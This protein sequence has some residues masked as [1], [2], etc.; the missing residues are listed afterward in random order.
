MSDDPNNLEPDAENT[1]SIESKETKKI[2]RSR[3]WL[4][5]FA[6]MALILVVGLAVILFRGRAGDNDDTTVY[7]KS[8]PAQTDD[9]NRG[10]QTVKLLP[11]SL[12]AANIETETVTMQ[13]AVAR[14]EVTG[15]VEENPQK[16][17]SVSSLVGGRVGSVNVSIGDRVS[18]GQTLATLTSTDAADMFGKWRAA[19]TK[20]T[21]AQNNLARVRKAENRVGVLQA[22]AKLDEAE[23]TLRR[24]QRLIELGAGA[25]K[26]LI[27]A[28]AAYKTALAD[29]NYQQTIQ[30]NKEIQEAEA[31]VETARSES[32]NLRQSLQVL[33]I[34]TS[35]AGANLRKVANIPIPAPIGG[36]ITER[37]VNT[38]A[39]VQ[40]GQAM[41]SIANISSLWITANVPQQELSAIRI[42]TPAEIVSGSDHI[43]S[44]VS[45]IDPQ[46]N[47]ETRTAKV[48]MSVTNPG[49]RLRAGMF[50]NVA[51]ETAEKVDG[52]DVLVAPTGSIQHLGDRTFVFIP[53]DDEPGEFIIRDVQIGA[54][55]N[56]YTEIKSG[57]KFGDK[58][59]VKG[60][61]AL[62][63]QMQKGSIEDDD[64]D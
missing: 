24:T 53:K 41:F 57:L 59:V 62:K 52:A 23:A 5:T 6:V 18:A 1:D 19:Q 2:Y 51:F 12:E 25:G 43:N 17:E 15:T 33:G 30:L 31:D 14:L 10:E 35:D 54:E 42:G 46:L 20:L 56:G 21:L 22:K 40:A 32:E 26:D 50:V 36:V 16:A 9:K 64:N 7:V 45:Y 37:Q 48:R 49:E 29:Y 44:Q 27:A 4:I 38:G 63:T 61:F 8:Q 34:S 39:G 58:V 3:A 11:E 13:P 28:N 47:E 60:S 55:R